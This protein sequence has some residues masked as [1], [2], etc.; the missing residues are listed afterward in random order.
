MT[1]AILLLAIPACTS[2]RA[3]G[4]QAPEH[5]TIAAVNAAIAVGVAAIEA[6]NP[7]EPGTLCASEPGD[8]PHTCPAKAE[9]R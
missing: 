3:G 5:G 2:G 1:L 4:L 9:G 6:L 8:P 7:D